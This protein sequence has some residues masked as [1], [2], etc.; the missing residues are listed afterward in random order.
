MRSKFPHFITGNFR[1]LVEWEVTRVFRSL[2]G[3]ADLVEAWAVRT[4]G[5]KGVE[6]RLLETPERTLLAER[7]LALDI[8]Y[9]DAVGKLWADEAG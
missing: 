8:A 3:G 5:R 9:A 2:Q 7:V 4:T 1:L 6:L